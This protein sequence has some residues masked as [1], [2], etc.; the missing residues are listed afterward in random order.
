[1]NKNDYNSA[2]D[3][4]KFSENLDEKT[5]EYLSNQAITK[6]NK[7]KK[8]RKFKIYTSFATAACAIAIILCVSMF[9]NNIS[10][11]ELAKSDS[12]ASV[13]YIKNPPN[14]HMSADL[15]WLTEEEIFSTWNTHI[16]MG[17]VLEIQNIEINYNGMEDYRS[18]AKI[19]IDKMYRGNKN[20]GDV[21][22]VLVP[23]PINTDL[24][25]EDTG[26]VSAMRIGTKGI[27]MPTKYDETHYCEMNGVR[28]YYNDFVEYG[29][30]DGERFAFLESENGLLFAEFAYESIQNATTLEEIEQY[31]MKMIK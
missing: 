16:F 8:S 2:I 7:N 11:I 1:M 18:I 29:F 3:N 19:R 26:V 30:A 15:V 20:I 31:V 28:V 17:T 10:D 4:V 27:F 22:D 14:I 12:N 13:K 9:N 21:V 6:Q 24:W 5:L 25:V 23:C